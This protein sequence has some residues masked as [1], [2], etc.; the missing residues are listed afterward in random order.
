M[1]A[2]GIDRAYTPNHSSPQQ[3][4][5]HPDHLNRPSRKTDANQTVVWD[6]YY[7]PYGQV[8]AITGTATNN[9]RFPGQYFLAESGL[10]YNWHR[11]YDPTIGRYT[12]ADPIADVLATQPTNL[13]G[14]SLIA[15]G[16]ISGG[17][18]LALNFASAGD[19]NRQIGL[20]LPGFVDGSSVYGYAR[21]A[22]TLHIDSNGLAGA[23]PSTPIPTG[24]TQLCSFISPNCEHAFQRCVTINP[25]STVRCY[26]SWKRCDQ[27]FPTIFPGGGG[28]LGGGR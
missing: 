28:T 1:S 17:S 3:W 20:E 11:H 24:N 8:R 12:Q 5:V 6:A 15:P 16:G 19:Y 18:Q 2:S 22:P 4:Y 23:G 25:G 14:T 26:E 13:D 9:L 7:W 21:S 10:H 27:G